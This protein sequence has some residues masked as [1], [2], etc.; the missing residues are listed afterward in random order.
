MATLLLITV[1]LPLVV[2]LGLFFAP[3]L[4]D[5]MA[6]QVALTTGLLTLALALILLAGFRSGVSGPPVRLGFPERRIRVLLAR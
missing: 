3:Q 6:R 1:F 2:S 5:R 4:E